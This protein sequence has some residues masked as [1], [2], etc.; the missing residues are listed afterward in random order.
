MPYALCMTFSESREYVQLQAQ[1]HDGTVQ[2]AQ[3]AQTSRQTF[4]LNKR[5]SAS[6]LSALYKLL[7]FAE[8]RADPVRLLQ[9]ARRWRR[10]SRSAAITIPPA[11]KRRPRDGGIP[12]QLGAGDGYRA[13][14]RA[15]L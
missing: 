10:A 9:S 3:L 15:G 11:T 1:Y 2:R 14:Q 5:L 8:C 4:R 13:D 12:C 7:G 6:L